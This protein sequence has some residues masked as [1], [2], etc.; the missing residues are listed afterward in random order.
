MLSDIRYTNVQLP[1]AHIHP[2]LLLVD[3]VNTVT[4]TLL[5][6]KPRDS[7]PRA[8]NLPTMWSDYA[9]CVNQIDGDDC[10]ERPVEAAVILPTQDVDVDA[11]LF[12]TR[13]SLLA[14]VDVK[15]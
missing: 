2:H 15:L 1:I 4:L 8:C 3:E 13:G 9:G 6:Q 11:E 10:F 5:P 7:V 12:A 14:A